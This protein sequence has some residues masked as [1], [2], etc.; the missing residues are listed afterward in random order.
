M[1]RYCM[2]YLFCPGDPKLV[3]LAQ[4]QWKTLSCGQ[5]WNKLQLL[6]WWTFIL[7]R[8]VK[9]LSSAS[10]QAAKVLG[11]TCQKVI[12]PPL[13]LLSYVALCTYLYV[14]YLCCILLC[15]P[16]GAHPHLPSVSEQAPVE[17]SLT[18][19]N[20]HDARSAEWENSHVN[21][22]AEE[23]DLNPWNPTSGILSSISVAFG[24]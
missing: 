4:V 15:F 16:T 5:C 10:A 9:V 3:H 23:Y 8:R 1:T 13:G 21:N 12:K 19:E 22:H 7:G 6:I 17:H 18:A 20:I 24:R 2:C 11:W 14:S